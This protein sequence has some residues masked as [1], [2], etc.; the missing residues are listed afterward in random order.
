MKNKLITSLITLTA[1]SAA[2]A[3]ISITGL[4]TPYVQ[5]FNT[6]PTANILATDES[7]PPWTDNSTL[8]GWYA[9]G[10]DFITRFSVRD[11]TNGTPVGTNGSAPG[12]LGVNNSTD[13]AFAP[14]RQNRSSYIGLRLVNDTSEIIPDF[15]ISFTGEQWRSNSTDPATLFFHY[16]VGATGLTAG[17]WAA[18]SQLDFTSPVT[19]GLGA[20]N[21]NDAA[22][23]VSLSHTITG[24]NLA[25][26]EEIWLRWANLRETANNGTYLGID[27]LTVTAIPEPGTLAL[28]A[29]ALGSLALF[30]RRRK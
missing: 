29:I 1:L 26:G 4:D 3:Q 28:V 30:R 11:G 21:G 13:R 18:V 24:V 25:P 15:L 27:D 7:A 23:Q 17:E 22:N 19:T 12:S 2:Q 5:D 20:L 14:M 8:E 6:L 16:Q 9:A 10:E